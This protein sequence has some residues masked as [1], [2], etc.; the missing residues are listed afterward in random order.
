MLQSL[1]G[2]TLAL[3]LLG[4]GCALRSAGTGQ[5]A[6]PM[7]RVL[8][9]GEAVRLQYLDWGGTGETVVLLP[10]LGNTA[11]IYGDF[12]PRLRARGFR[13]VSLTRRGHGR[14]S[15]PAS[16]YEPDSLAHDIRVLL[17]TLGAGRA[18]LVGHSFA[19]VEITRF[20]ARYPERVGK[21]VYL[22]AAY[23]RQMQFARQRQDP[24]APA[25]PSPDDR[26]SWSPCWRSSAART[27]TTGAC[28]PRPPRR[29]SANA[30]CPTPRGVCRIAR[31]GASMAR[32][33]PR[34][35]RRHPT[36]RGFAPR[37]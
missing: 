16:G 35:P 34:R 27:S 21:L 13:V 19:G 28:G 25:R 20:A 26:G 4:S 32:C 3:L 22:D 24:A 29:T 12:A 8:A 23:D 11:Y 37:C 14:S 30:T 17:D 36:I 6:V 15:Q 9:V 31:R 33:W 7:D 18:H 1:S 10:G 5:A 2:L